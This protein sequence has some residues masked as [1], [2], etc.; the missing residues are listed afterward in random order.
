MRAGFFED[1]KGD[2]SMT[3]LISFLSTMIS[4]VLAIVGSCIAI[5]ETLT[6]NT[7][8]V[9]VSIIGLAVGMFSSG[10]ATKLISKA[11]EVAMARVDK[12]REV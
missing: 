7:R 8:N 4:I 3:R 5:Y 11:T 10:S 6:I 2:R 1:E 12:S 9:G